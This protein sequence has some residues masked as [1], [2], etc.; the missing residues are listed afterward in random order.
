MKASLIYLTMRSTNTILTIAWGFLLTAI[1]VRTVGID[2]FAFFILISVMGIYLSGSNF[3]I[4]NLV[5][6]HFRERFVSGNLSGTGHIAQIALS[7]YLL[8]TVLACI[9]FLSFTSLTGFAEDYRVATIAFFFLTVL[10]FPWLMVRALCEAVDL[11]LFFEAVEVSRR[12]FQIFCILLMLIDVSPAAAFGSA[13]LCWAVAYIAVLIPLL[14][15]LGIR[16]QDLGNFSKERLH[17]FANQY[18]TQM[19]SSITFSLSEF[20]I[21]N[22]AYLYVP[23]VFKG[24]AVLVLYDTF[25]KLVRATISINMIA[26]AGLMPRLTSAYHHQKKQETRNIFFVVIGLSL[27]AMSAFTLAITL[28]G[29]TIFEILLDG[30]VQP[31]WYFVV[32][33]V[34]VALANAVQNSAGAFIVHIGKIRDAQ[35]LALIML[36]AM[37]GLAAIVWTAQL[38]FNQFL[39][40]FALVYATGSLAWLAIAMK[41]ISCNSKNEQHP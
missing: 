9:A 39:V 32:A 22:Y 13:S 35:N 2:D 23:F 24:G 7:A 4:S 17:A 28:A 30:Q 36:A 34:T 8:I 38:S 3:G 14:K 6:A 40:G 27:F 16:W 5:Y 33:T 21:Y 25:Y 10:N 12:S 29:K 20:A 31:D 11:Y 19:R 41:I 26:S 15:K 37:V 1:M 18:G